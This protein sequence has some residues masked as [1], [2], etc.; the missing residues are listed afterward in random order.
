MPDE[1][2]LPPSSNH[3]TP[4]G[5]PRGHARACQGAGASEFMGRAPA[6][7][8][9]FLTWPDWIPWHSGQAS[10]GGDRGSHPGCSHPLRHRHIPKSSLS[11]SQP[12]NSYAS[13]SS[14]AWLLRSSSTQPLQ[15]ARGLAPFLPREGICYSILY[16]PNRHRALPTLA[17]R[18]V[19]GYDGE[20]DKH[21]FCSRGI[22]SRAA[23][24]RPKLL[25]HMLGASM[26]LAAP[27]E[28]EGSP[29]ICV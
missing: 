26:R 4:R 3:S 19:L 25:L 22:H 12:A 1:N 16:L 27:G 15:T 13:F 14:P 21:H 11:L 20:R 23:M 17:Q 9:V 10:G 6:S 7:S 2:V 8:C 18:W 29:I 5:S 24:L 28:Q